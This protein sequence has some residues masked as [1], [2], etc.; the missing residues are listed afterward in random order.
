M[1]DV[2]LRGVDLNLLVVLDALLEARSV[3]RAAERLAMSQPAVSRAL[4]RSRDLFSDALLVQGR[5]GYALTARAEALQ[6]TLR[7]ALADVGAVLETRPF[8]PATATGRMRILTP[9]MV[10]AALAPALLARLGDEAPGLDLDILPP[11]SQPLE[12]LE[13]DEADIGIG[14]IDAAPAGIMRRSLY[15]DGFVTL[16]RADHPHAGEPLSLDRFLTLGHIAISVTGTGPAPVDMA[17]TAMG[18]E[19]RVRARVPSFFAALE[20]VAR[21]D[22]VITLPTS[23]ALTAEGMGRFSITPPPL[24]MGQ[25]TMS[26]MWHARRQ[27]DPRHVW[28]RRAIVDAAAGINAQA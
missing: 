1:R 23:L 8:D 21:T 12:T 10:A 11:G 16:M 4:A 15:D 28:L 17:L 26:L 7:R 19:R 2:E 5:G 20:I 9:D 22:L 18:R 13:R 27:D 25:F 14:V 3:T 24:D 6:P